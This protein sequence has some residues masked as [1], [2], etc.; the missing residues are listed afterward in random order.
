MV[1]MRER[2]DGD[3]HRESHVLM[4]FK[5]ESRCMCVLMT[6]VGKLVSI[7]SSRRD[8]G[9]E[10]GDGEGCLGVRWDVWG[11]GRA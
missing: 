2:E 7:H 5:R 10:I 8:A 11:L 9:G 6:S 1:S 4:R 3:V